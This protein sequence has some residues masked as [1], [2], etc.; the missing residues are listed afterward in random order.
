MAVGIV[1]D[2]EWSRLDQTVE[3]AKSFSDNV[4]ALGIDSSET[5]ATIIE[6]AGIEKNFLSVA[7][8]TDFSEARNRLLKHVEEHCNADWILWLMAGECFDLSTFADFALFIEKEANLNSLYFQ[9]LRRNFKEDGSRHDLDQETI[10][11]RLMPLRK[12][13]YFSGPVRETPFLSATNLMIQLSAA[14]G[15][16]V[17]PMKYVDQHIRLLRGARNLRI[18]ENLQSQGMAVEDEL[19]IFQ[20]EVR[21]DLGDWAAARNDYLRLVSETSKSNLRLEGYYALCDTTMFTSIQPAETTQILLQSLD[22][23]PV[24]MQLL[25]LMGKHMQ[26]QGHWDIAARTFDTA[27]RYGQISLD[28]WHRRHIREMA[29]VGLSLI[30][31]LQDNQAKAIQV[32]ESNLDQIEDATEC[33]RY[34]FD[35]YIAEFQEFK[36]HDAAAK[37]F[38][39]EELDLMQDVLSGACRASAGA[40][41]AA[42]LPLE[43]AYA[44]GCRD[45][46]CLRWYAL[47]LI[48][49]ERF[50][51]A[52]PIIEEWTASAPESKEAKAYLAAAKDPAHFHRIID[53]MKAKQQRILRNSGKPSGSLAFQAQQAVQEMVRSSGKASGEASSKP[54]SEV[55]VPVQFEI[56]IAGDSPNNMFFEM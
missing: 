4:F 27:L 10:D 19:L 42:I 5:T 36:A 3:N 31:R 55:D 20:A 17:G 48:S 21:C 32:L 29:A 2:N 40:Y 33:V 44:D 26:G 38:E 25:T 49:L 30:H 12:G 56:E 14:P 35:L 52:I 11:A 13:L 6:Q 7:F 37:V 34:L 15:R 45:L 54:L 28:V 16:I 41:E 53:Q 1:V 8:C 50:D 24:D 43:A 51:D 18:L 22:Q 9:V 39:G 23:F 47:S 46:L